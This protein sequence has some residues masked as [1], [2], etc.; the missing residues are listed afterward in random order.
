MRSLRFVVP[1][2]LTSMMLSLLG[3]GY[4][5]VIHNLEEDSPSQGKSVRLKGSGVV[6]TETRAV[7]GFSAVHLKG[8]GNVTL[9]Q[10]GKES[11][12]I[13]A[14]DNI[15]PVLT[16]KVVKGVLEL[17]VEKG[18]NLQPQKPIRYTVEVKS[19]EGLALSGAG[20]IE[21]EGIQTSKLAVNA[22][23][24]GNTRIKG[25]AGELMVSL[26]GSG[27]VNGE[28]LQAKQARVTLSGVG[29]ATVR[30]SDTLDAN[31][32]GVGSV[33]Y[34]GSPKVTKSVSGVGSIR[35]R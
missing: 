6:K 11:L 22:S 8:V 7:S 4:V 17:S 10:S 32:S 12:K 25:Q 14:E 3:C 5:Q 28:A 30:V 27:N 13:E 19:L 21:A 24:A 18:H 35:A 23:G 2:C 9:R 1:I 16:S 34:L 33:Q 29:N 20:N 31:V 15:L 26:T